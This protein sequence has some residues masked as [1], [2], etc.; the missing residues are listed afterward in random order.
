MR[1]LRKAVKVALD[2]TFSN[3]RP[4][5]LASLF[6]DD[7]RLR[8][9]RAIEE[10]SASIMKAVRKNIEAEIDKICSER[11]LVQHLNRLDVLCAEQIIKLKDMTMSV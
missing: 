11:D 7:L 4:E 10:R 3:C 9:G 5:M 2:K 8:H 1:Q 6:T